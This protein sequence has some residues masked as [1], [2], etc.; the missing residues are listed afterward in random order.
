METE[1]KMIK[2]NCAKTRDINNPYEIWVNSSGWIWKVLKKY[3]LDDNKP[4]ARWFCGVKS[5]Y[6]YGSFELGDT[7][8]S[9]IKS[10]A[11]KLTENEIQSSNPSARYSSVNMKSWPLRAFL[12]RRPFCP[13][14]FA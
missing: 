2:N 4:Y 6:T 9:E 13:V 10:N 12:D 11:R 5:P 14:Q 8:V 7:Y 3:Q 1:N